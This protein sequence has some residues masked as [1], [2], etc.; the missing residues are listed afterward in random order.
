M[1]KE[2]IIAAAKSGKHILCEKPILLYPEESEEVERVLKENNIKLMVAM[3]CRFI[4]HYATAKRVIDKGEIGSIVSIHAHRRGRGPP[5]AD[6][7]WDLD[8]SGG[9]PIDLAIHDIDL[10]Q[11]F[12]GSND[13]IKSVYA[14][15]SNLVYSEINT[16]DTVVITLQSQSGVLIT[17]EASWAE[18]DLKDQVGSNTKMIVYGEEGTIHIDPSRQPAIKNTEL[19]GLEPTLEELDQLPFFVDQVGTFARAVLNDEEV[20]IPLADGLS[21]LRVARA[22][23]QSLKS[24]TV[25]QL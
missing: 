10:I 22:A 14:I 16:W 3:I 18:P 24:G 6:W 20:P 12:L 1:H 25:V 11:W 8:K 4:P 15:G 17:I 19:D 23:L 7:F 13:P 21:A 9:I 2:Y 5:T